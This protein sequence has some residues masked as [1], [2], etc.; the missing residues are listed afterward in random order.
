MG[1]NLRPKEPRCS[2]IRNCQRLGWWIPCYACQVSGLLQIS[3]CFVV[4]S[5]LNTWIWL[6]LFIN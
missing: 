4:C 5:T 2:T 6:G 3:L 1:V